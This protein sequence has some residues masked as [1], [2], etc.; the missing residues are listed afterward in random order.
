M[1]ETIKAIL[2]L[3]WML[4][5]AAFALAAF[6]M[7]N[8]FGLPNIEVLRTKQLLFIG[9]GALLGVFLSLLDYRILRVRSEVSGGLWL[10]ALVL[11]L[12]ALLIG[13]RV[14]GTTSWLVLGPIAFGPVEFAKVALIAVLAKYFS[15][16]AHEFASLRHLIGSF[17]FAAIPAFIAIL[18]PDLGSALLFIA[19]WLG[20]VAAF[21][22]PLRHLFV[23]ACIAGILGGVFWQY[24]LHPYQQE[25]VAAFFNPE[26]DPQGASWQAQQAVTSAGSGGFFGQGFSETLQA[27]LGLLPEA[28]TDFAFAAL[29]EQFGF[30]GGIIILILFAVILWRIFKTAWNA[31]NNFSRACATGVAVLFVVE[32]TVN[33]GMNVGLLPVVG[34]PLPFVS[35][36]GSHII[37]AF[38]LIGLVESVRLH[39]PQM[40]RAGGEEALI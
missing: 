36:G 39:Q 26:D 1:P 31:T 7:V 9:C 29:V 2:R 12:S 3:D 38:L 11:L 5:G 14:R 22:L 20:I 17:L 24:G 27:K 10:L 4:F 21:G 34:I 6:G 19:I 25:R 28:A 37:A 33:V 18:Y 32:I 15:S 13:T 23:L 16:R 40:L 30:L 8:L 35:Y